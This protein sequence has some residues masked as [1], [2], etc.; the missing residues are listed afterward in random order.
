MLNKEP[1]STIS[2][3]NSQHSTKHDSGLASV[4][5]KHPTCVGKQ[6]STERER[7]SKP[8]TAETTQKGNKK[9]PSTKHL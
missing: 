8:M 6:I 3:S 9:H 5:L 7:E 1:I 2:A 4:K